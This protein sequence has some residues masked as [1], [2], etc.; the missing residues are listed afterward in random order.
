MTAYASIDTVQGLLPHLVLSTTTKPTTA[1]VTEYLENTA[2]EI[3]AALAV[4]GVAVPVTAPAWFVTDLENLNAMGAAAH[5]LMAWRPD[6]A[7]P[8][9]NGQG[10]TLWRAYQARLVE[11]RRGIGIPVGVAEAEIV[12]APR[13]YLVDTGAIGS[14][15][16][17]DDFGSTVDANPVFT[18]ARVF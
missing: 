3:E 12:K 2:G 11:F 15:T 9:G 7:G 6:Q 17:V 8:T 16:A 14:D 5:A 1:Q 10:Y 18:M 13:S 4:K